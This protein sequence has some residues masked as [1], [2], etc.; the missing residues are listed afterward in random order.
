M[1]TFVNSATAVLGDNVQ[2]TVSISPSAGVVVQG[3]TD[4]QRSLAQAQR[5]VKDF[6]VGATPD[7]PTN[8]ALRISHN[9]DGRIQAKLYIMEY[10]TESEPLNPCILADLENMYA[11]MNTPPTLRDTIDLFTLANDQARLF[12]LMAT[13]TQ[14]RMHQ[15]KPVH[16]YTN[17]PLRVLGTGGPGTGKTHVVAAYE[18]HMFHNGNGHA[19]RK[20]SYTWRAAHHLNSAV[21][22]ATS[23]CRLFGVNP[24]QGGPRHKDKPQTAGNAAAISQH[25][26]S[27][28]TCMLIIDE[29]SMI[30]QAHFAAMSDSAATV[31]RVVNAPSAMPPSNFFGNYSCAIFF[32]MLQH[33]PPG[34]GSALYVNHHTTVRNAPTLNLTANPRAVAQRH[35]RRAWCSFNDVIVLTKQHRMVGDTQLHAFTKLFCDRSLEGP[36][37]DA[38]ERLCNAINERVVT[39]IQELDHLNPHCV[40]TR[41]IERMHLNH[42]LAIRQVCTQPSSIRSCP[43]AITQKPLHFF[44]I[45]T[46]AIVPA[47]QNACASLLIQRVHF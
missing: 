42:R 1:I 8:R 2:P 20:A 34:N 21:S 25:L 14:N 39:D 30:S 32:D 7:L 18:W 37:R 9:H 31:H 22:S 11:P 24:F 15:G 45:P 27:P 12:A 43:F 33:A 35:G 44:R 41:N 29:A 26:L 40:C 6:T 19:A 5:R 3:C 16:D 10:D 46:H 38:I 13:D 36:S 23:T 47:T 17:P 28:P 4:I